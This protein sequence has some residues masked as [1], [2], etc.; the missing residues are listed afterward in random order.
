MT[1]VECVPPT[2]RRVVVIQQ[3]EKLKL[4]QFT[5]IRNVVHDMCEQMQMD[6][7]CRLLL[8]NGKRILD[9]FKMMRRENAAPVPAILSQPAIARIAE[10]RPSTN[11][12]SVEIELPEI[13]TYM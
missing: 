4:E 10:T 7:K 5:P 11:K 6:G 12:I 9:R 2:T 13:A 8:K 1:E 3:V